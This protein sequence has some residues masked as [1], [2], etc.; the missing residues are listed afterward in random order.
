MQRKRFEHQ[1]N[2][3]NSSFFPVSCFFKIIPKKLLD[4]YHNTKLNRRIPTILYSV[5]HNT[6]QNVKLKMLKER[7][8]QIWVINNDKFVI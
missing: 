6:S 7:D 2:G 5:Y 1:F 3:K 4:I 8:I